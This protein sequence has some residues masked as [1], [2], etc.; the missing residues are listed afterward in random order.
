MKYENNLQCLQYLVLRKSVN[1]PLD[2]K[3]LC[4][5]IEKGSL[6]DEHLPG[7]KKKDVVKSKLSKLKKN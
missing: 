7:N 5:N 4:D 6:V 1:A 3:K 2:D